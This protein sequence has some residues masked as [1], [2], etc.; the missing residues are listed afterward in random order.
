M[1]SLNRFMTVEI[2]GQPFKVGPRR[3][4]NKIQDRGKNVRR[5]VLLS[6]GVKLDTI[7]GRKNSKLLKTARL[8][9]VPE[10]LFKDIR[11]ETESFSDRHRS[12]EV[13]QTKTNNL[14]GWNHI[15]QGAYAY[16]GNTPSQENEPKENTCS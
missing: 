1:P 13:A 16:A 8:L 10:G 7:T 5:V 11:R 12:R 15:S 2:G 14:G 9:H 4:G 6:T 3:L